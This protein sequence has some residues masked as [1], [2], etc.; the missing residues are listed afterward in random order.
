MKIFLFSIFLLIAQFSFSQEKNIRGV[1]LNSSYQGIQ[2]SHILNLK[3]QKG[4]VSNSRGEF[5]ILAKIGDSI[6]IS[7]IQ[8]KTKLIFVDK[9]IYDNTLF[10]VFLD[11]E[12]I[13]L[14]EVKIQKKM[15]GFLELDVRKTPEDSIGKIVKN[16]VDDIRNIPAYE[17]MSMKLG[18]D[19]IHLRKPIITSSPLNSFGVG[20]SV[21]LPNLAWKKEK[22]LMKKLNFKENFPRK[23][24]DEFGEVFFYKTLKIPK[25]RFYHFIDYCSNFGIEDLYKKD[26]KLEIIKILLSESK[27]YLNLINTNT[28]FQKKE[29]M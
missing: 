3:T 25:T 9:E 23:L 24:K 1:I 16:L 18:K 28:D 5:T 13:E 8:F 6:K 15:S 4:S 29:K 27:H 26:K 10:K 11:S 7:N 20:A 19:E 22:E 17:I 14:D 12:F 2:N 21:A